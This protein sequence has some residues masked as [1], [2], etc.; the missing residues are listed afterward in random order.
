MFGRKGMGG[1]DGSSASAQSAA[2][3]DHDSGG[4]RLVIGRGL[5]FSGAI[6]DCEHLVIA[7]TVASEVKRCDSI[8]IAA[9]GSF[10]G[11]ATAQ[12]AEIAGE[13]DGQLTVFGAL[14]VRATA[15]VK[16]R[17][18]YGSLTVETGGQLLG[19]CDIAAPMPVTRPSAVVVPLWPA[20]HGH[21]ED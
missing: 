13:F 21:G 9:G 5:T 19:T 7:G 12:N 6:A 20:R 14:R 11:R 18:S 15:I 8:E 17:I 2:R 4:Q 1:A 10:H 16:G 3:S